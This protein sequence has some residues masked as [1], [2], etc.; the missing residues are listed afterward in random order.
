MLHAALDL[1]IEQ[2]Q[3]QNKIMYVCTWIECNLFGKTEIRFRSDKYLHAHVHF[4][5]ELNVY[6]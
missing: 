5:L 6:I 1:Q 4:E 2:A 3:D